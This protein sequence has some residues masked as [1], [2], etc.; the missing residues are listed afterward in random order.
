MNFR[1]SIDF[2][3]LTRV[4]ALHPRIIALC[5]A[6]NS[7]WRSAG[8]INYSSRTA[9]FISNKMPGNSFLCPSSKRRNQSNF[10]LFV[11]QTPTC[12]Q[13]GKKR[14][15]PRTRDT[16][17]TT[18]RSSPSLYQILHRFCTE[19]KIHWHMNWVFFVWRAY[20]PIKRLYICHHTSSLSLASPSYK[21]DNGYGVFFSFFYIPSSPFF[22]FFTSMYDEETT[23]KKKQICL[24]PQ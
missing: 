4:A 24:A 21:S 20:F 19:K 11:L 2:P 8:D 3:H 6:R 22:S 7:C 18:S 16:T 17:T 9:N 1:V 14:P 5:L 13:F 10:S 15:S 23:T 12:P